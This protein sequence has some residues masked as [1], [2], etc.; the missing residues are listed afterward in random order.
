[1]N[2]SIERNSV[3]I[4]ANKMIKCSLIKALV[5]AG[6]GASALVS[7][8]AYAAV[9]VPDVP[10]IVQS[11]TLPA[12]MTEWMANGGVDYS[13]NPV[14]ARLGEHPD[15]SLGVIYIS[16]MQQLLTPGGMV[17]LLQ[18]LQRV[19]LT[20]QWLIYTGSWIITA[21]NSRASWPKPMTKILRPTTV[22]WPQAP[23]SQLKMVLASKTKPAVITRARPSVS[24]WS[25]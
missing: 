5:V 9:T 13:W 22:S 23:T 12:D 24:S 7:V 19:F 21:V 4:S 17:L 2:N 8:A 14:N 11:E 15:R 16:P 6:F 25:Y 20:M 3:S 1:M 10:A 18:H